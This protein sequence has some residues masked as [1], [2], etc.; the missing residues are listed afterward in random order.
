M[1]D[2]EYRNDDIAVIGIG[3]HI[4]DASTLDEYWEIYKN[5]IDCVRDLPQCRQDD[6]VELLEAY[7]RMTDRYDGG[8]LTYG[9]ACFLEHIDY[10]DNEFFNIPPR[11]AQV[12]E[13][14][15]RILLQTICEAF[16]DAGYTAEALNDTNTGV[17]IGYTPGSAK[18]NYATLIGYNNPELA[19]FSNVGNMPCITPSRATYAFN[20]HGPSVLIDC[21]C[22]SSLVAIH[23]ACESI[24]N[25]TCTMAIAGGIRLHGFPIVSEDSNVGFETDDNKTRVFDNL[26][27]GAAIGEGSACVLLKPYS[28]AVKDKNYIYGVI[29]ST[30][31]NN[32]GTSA[33]ITAPNPAA[34]TAVIQ[35]AINLSGESPEDIDYV[36]THGTATNLGDPIEFRG[37]T[38]AYEKYTDKKQFCGLSSSKSNIGHLYEAAG[39]AS[40]IKALAALKYKKIPGSKNFLFPNAKIDF[41]NSPFY[42]SNA[43]KDWEKDG[44]RL[45]GISAF[46]ISGTNCHIILKEY[47]N[48]IPEKQYTA[49]Y[50][51]IAISAKSNESL[52]NNVRA[53]AKYLQSNNV[54]VD[55]FTANVNLYRSHYDKRLAI[56]FEDKEELTEILLKLSMSDV[57]EWKGTSNI[58]YVDG[59]KSAKD[60]NY[61]KLNQILVECNKVMCKMPQA[62]FDD[63]TLEEHYE[64]IR[65]IAEMYSLGARIKWEKLYSGCEPYHIPV[66]YYQFKKTRCWLPKT[67]LKTDWTHIM[68]GVSTKEPVKTIET[69]QGDVFY[70]RTFV[71][72]EQVEQD[73]N[74]NKCILIYING[75][76]NE[77]LTELLSNYFIEV[78]PVSINLE[79]MGRIGKAEYFRKLYNSLSFRNVTNIVFDNIVCDDTVTS[80]QELLTIQ[81]QQL[82]SISELYKELVSNE[83]S[84]RITP[85]IHQ[86]FKVSG[87]EKKLNPFS[88]P[89]FGLCKALNRMYKAIH[90]CCIDVDDETDYVNIVK[91]ICSSAKNDIVSYRQGKRYVEGLEEARQSESQEQQVVKDNGVYIISGGLGGIGYETAMEFTRRAKDVN[92]IL[93][94]RTPLPDESQWESVTDEDIKE[95]IMRLESLRKNAKNADYFAVNIADYDK[96]QALVKDV[97]NTYGKINGVVHAAGVPGGTTLD[98]LDEAYV[99]KLISPKILGT[100]VLD[101][102][103][104]DQNLDFF[105]MYSSIST[106]FS[107]ADL[108]AY[109]SG[110]IFQDCYSEYRKTLCSGKSITVNWATWSETGMSVKTNFT[111]DTLFQSVKTKDAISYLFQVLQGESGSTVIAQLNLDN[112]ISLLLKTYPMMYSEK[113]ENALV[114]LK[115]S[116]E[117]VEVKSVGEEYAS[118]ESKLIQICCDNLG[119]EEISIEDNFFELG[120]DSIM[121]GIIYKDINKVYPNTIQVTDMFSCPSVNLLAEYI[122]EKLENTEVIEQTDPVVQEEMMPQKKNVTEP[123]VKEEQKNEKVI[124]KEQVSSYER[125]SVYQVADPKVVADDDDGKVAIIG[126]GLNIPTCRNLD[127]YW[128]ML[129]NGINVVRDIP[130][131]RSV[132]IKKHLG[133]YMDAEKIRFRRCGYLNEVNKFDYEYFGISP[134]DAS[135]LDPVAR[136]FTECCV[137][138]IDDAGYGTQA[139]SG[140]NTGIF[141]GY[142]ANMG[143]AY[144]RLLYEMDSKLFNDAL[145]IG[146]VSMCASRAA[147]ALDLKGPAMVIDTACSSSLVALHM[148]CQQII[149]GKCDMMLVG[150]ASIMATPLNDGSG[151]GF[152]SEEE[153]TRAFANES[154]GAAIAEGVG[155]VLL[156]SLKQAKKDGDS[157]YAVIRGSAVNQDGSS[158][159]IAAPNYKAQ[160]EVIQAAWKAAKVHPEEISY[161][162]SHGTG[163]ALGDPIEI[164]GITDAFSMYTDKKQIC[165]LG[166]VKTNLGHSNEAS[167][168]IS[169][170]KTILIMKFKEIPPTLNF[171][172]PNN[173]IDF[174]NTPVYLCDRKQPLRI[175]GDKALIGISGF[176]MSGTNAHIVI[177]EPP[178]QEK[179]S[180]NNKKEVKICTV[181]AKSKNALARMIKNYKSYLKENQGINFNDFICTLNIGRA[182]YSHRIAFI[183]KNASDL[184]NKLEKLERVSDLDQ[185]DYSWCYSGHYAIVPESKKSRFEYEIT[186]KEKRELDKKADVL[187]Y[188][189]D[190]KNEEELRKVLALYTK[191]ADVKWKDIYQENFT[192]L[193][194]PVYSFEK[195]YAWYKIPEPK[196][197]AD[198]EES[199]LN[200]FFHNKT[201]I[202][203]DEFDLIEVKDNDTYIV[204]HSDSEKENKI[205]S[206]LRKKGILIVDI[207]IGKGG[208]AKLD[209]FHY[210][211]DNTAEGYQ[212]VFSELNTRPIRKIIHT[213]SLRD[214]MADTVEQMKEEMNY[215]VNSVYRMALGIMKA[216][217]DQ[218]VDLVVI[219]CNG[220]NVCG[221]EKKILPHNAMALNLGRVI[222]LEY[223]SLKCSALDVDTESSVDDIVNML[224]TDPTFYIKALR[225]GDI[226]IEQ[227]G[228][229][230]LAEETTNRFVDG[231]T[232]IVTGGTSGIGLQT[233][234][235]ISRL[236]DCNLVLVSRSGNKA[237]GLSENNMVLKEIKR[238]NC[239]VQVMACD[240]SNEQDVSRMLE[241]VRSQFGRI[242]GIIHCAGITKPGFMIR[243][244]KEVF[245]SVISPKMIGIWLL[246]HMT[247][248]DNLDFVLLNS[249]CVTFTGEAGQSDYV[250]ANTF[251]DSYAEYMNS[252]GRRTYTVN[253]VAWKETGMAYDCGTNVDTYTKAITTNDAETALEQLLNSTPQRTI[254]G[255]Y[256]EIPDLLEHILMSHDAIEPSFLAKLWEYKSVVSDKADI[257]N[258]KMEEEEV[259]EENANNE[260]IANITLLGR[261]DTEYTDME[262]SVGQI[263]CKVL[264]YEEVDIY[265][266]FF[267]MGGDSILLNE[268]HDLIDKKFPG[269][270]KVADLFE[271]DSIISLAEYI[272]S[273]TKQTATEEKKVEE[274]LESTTKPENNEEEMTYCELSAAQE[275][276]YFDY[277]MSRNKYI[278]NIGFIT[279][280]SQV[281]YENICKIA[282]MF[283]SEFEMCRSFFKVHDG[284]LVRNILPKSQMPEIEVGRVQVEDVDKVDYL[285]YA[286]VFKLNQFPLFNLTVFE[287]GTK[288]YVFCDIHHILLDGY[289]TTLIQECMEEYVQNKGKIER[290]LYP[291]SQYVEFEKEYGKSD[292][293]RAMGE[294]WRDNL[295]NFDFSNIFTLKNVDATS[296]D[297]VSLYL[298]DDLGKRL[299]EVSKDMGIT[300]FNTI[301]AAIGISLS[302]LTSRND[303]AIITPVLNRYKRE[304]MNIIG[305]F[306][307]VIPLRMQLDSN[308]QIGQYLNAVSNV[309]R[310]GLINQYYKFN[311][312]VRDMKEEK[313]SFYVYLDFEDDSL[314]KQRQTRDIP[315]AVDVP[316]YPMDIEVKKLH[317]K[318]S[319][320]I[321]FEEQYVSK[322]EAEVFLNNLKSTLKAIC[323][324]N[325]NEKDIQGVLDLLD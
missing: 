72:N 106:I 230:E 25:G 21:A 24:K 99:E 193:H 3:L 40:F 150:G 30:A 27:S 269:A 252:I 100:F 253:W 141:L 131:E 184:V 225:K 82:L 6:L 87:Q 77:K 239:N 314:K 311:D 140:S 94:G 187:C 103:T 221:C 169:L 67:K 208:Y 47:N 271:F 163:T 66:P 245:D 142:T 113:I 257:A 146:Q 182:H 166:S 127:E 283:V 161:I 64:N 11:E 78:Q 165:G 38:R 15:Q 302:K 71:L 303:L 23:D 315:Y 12:M 189:I 304:F 124:E 114:K 84:V 292:E 39:V 28:E 272:D 250:V 101:R 2:N 312:L 10:F 44:L 73:Q 247:R 226:Y 273:Q 49:K 259:E 205:S 128:E 186:K 310:N 242:N 289:S 96:V 97:A 220:Y 237:K 108:P 55:L 197:V 151:I 224:F 177:E 105:L 109:I 291:Y 162:E 307:N 206:E 244:E 112:K 185:V 296:Y 160:S 90:S 98:K 255:Q 123:C 174:V 254:I 178:K 17:Y 117:T 222:R 223:K 317:D 203:R 235:M 144:N 42:I 246:D 195:S 262:Y 50:N 45:C 266:G 145:S 321:L 260:E 19:K 297:K 211:V 191:G 63:D 293:Y 111:I 215:G 5:N 46:G 236:V 122:S 188:N 228:E 180:L 275:R 143:N 26:A 158:F 48:Q 279:D 308:S 133:Q 200:T 282:N 241:Q 75:H 173:N 216:R 120:A 89:V 248:N 60:V 129:I 322:E 92:L 313:P 79:E 207:I 298:D 159:G 52:Q 31:V 274:K 139:L 316:K 214:V 51:M 81:K 116:K 148:A 83:V 22:S 213:C 53:Y 132:D 61:V 256:N 33:S 88:V 270:V 43:T 35:R 264:G 172:A 251:L 110:N 152:E 286:K 238:Q 135:L 102:T 294:Y 16:D 227:Y 281:T 219:S 80:A 277:R 59:K 126:V 136:I 233:A 134:R 210:E 149:N 249:S 176:G 267:K 65:A 175:K 93:L 261:V 74:V 85:I 268:M 104:R 37:L 76:Q 301:L 41:C 258:S 300:V 36:E 194:I 168:V 167:G 276:I 265:E 201:W 54:D 280:K 147:Y 1:R 130:E 118:I 324:G 309:T 284:K 209:D 56:V 320:E 32:D 155:T 240:I 299:K 34:Q 285:Q 192:R 68:T 290:I 183:C 164:K 263:Y 325:K 107:S 295:K 232:Y 13:P 69:L 171:W 57:S 86:C 119:Y 125:K 154:T 153:K 278:Y 323:M 4:A 234:K 18:D 305:P 306:I 190:N 243:K 218:V 229:V 29:R 287:D 202:R 179:I 121:L 319:I 217:F 212:K 157:I 198:K 204:I 14:V 62:I 231:G 20:L 196:C 95:R 58:Y 288:R 137:E 9:K 181:S 91:E 70:K 115:T 170:L 318:Y 156:K 199:R 7:Q 8:K 138:A